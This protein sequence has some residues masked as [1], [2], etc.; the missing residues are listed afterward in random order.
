MELEASHDQPARFAFSFFSLPLFLPRFTSWAREEDIIVAPDGGRV[1][2]LFLFSF[3]SSF[4]HS[5]GAAAEGEVFFRRPSVF[6]SLS[7][8]KGPVIS[9]M[10][11][12]FFTRE[13][14]KRQGRDCC[15][16]FFPFS[17]VNPRQ[18]AVLPFPSLP[19]FFFRACLWDEDN[20][21]WPS[22]KVSHPPFPFP[23]PPPLFHIVAR[24]V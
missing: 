22:K 14:K 9:R 11:S 24:R 3:S 5:P 4:S 2:P 13:K 20:S 6:F 18:R 15:F 17:A 21:T 1:A 23:S 19:L 16:S 8:R 7:F 12:L 10:A